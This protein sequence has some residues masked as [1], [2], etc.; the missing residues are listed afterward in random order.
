MIELVII[1]GIFGVLLLAGTDF[2]IATIKNS[3]R[4]AMENEVR[5]NANRIM[6]DIEAEARKADPA[7]GFGFVGGSGN[8]QIPTIN[9]T[10]TRTVA[11]SVNAS[12]IFT[13]TVTLGGVVGSPTILNSDN[14]VVLKCTGCPGSS[15]TPGFIVSQPL[16]TDPLSISITVQNSSLFTRSD[17]CAKVSLSDIIMARQY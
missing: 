4:S 13:K 11:Y 9:V 6:Q 7:V 10:P 17:F 14:V 12:G 1:L 3:N 2:L 15:C 16:L 8:L 5:Q